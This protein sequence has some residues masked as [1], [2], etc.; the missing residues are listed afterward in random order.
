MSH[1]PRLWPVESIVVTAVVWSYTMIVC[2]PLQEVVA[3]SPFCL[4]LLKGRAEWPICLLAVPFVEMVEYWFGTKPDMG[5]IA[6]RY[7]PAG[8]M[9]S[10]FTTILVRRWWRR[11]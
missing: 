6:R 2:I 7:W 9:A 10:A 5:S 1:S 8:L 11:S 4:S 3:A